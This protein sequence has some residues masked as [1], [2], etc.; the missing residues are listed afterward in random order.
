MYF[1]GS[2][3]YVGSVDPQPLAEAIG[4][5]GEEAWYEF[6]GRQETFDAHR[7]TQTIPLLFDM[8]GRHGEPTVWPRLKDVR[9]A[10]DPI[11]NA[12][13]AANPPAPGFDRPGY[14]VRIILTRLSPG[15]IIDEHVDHGHSLKRSHRNHV[16]IATNNLV[17]FKVGGEVKQMGAG[18]IWEI[19]NRDDHAVANKSDEPRVHIILDYVVPG[20]EIMDPDDGLILA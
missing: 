7:H 6:V 18:E 1:Q 8:D 14:F 19:N 5:L 12:I 11:L 3:R 4:R 2:F 10:L 13:R 15:S 9:S 17:D 16:A 20:E